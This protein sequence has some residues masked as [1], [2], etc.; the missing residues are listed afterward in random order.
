MRDKYH[1]NSPFTRTQSTKQTNRQN[2]TRDIEMKNSLTVTEGIREGIMEG[3][4]ARDFRNSYK[5]HMD[6][7]NGLSLIHI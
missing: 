1:M 2:I 4:G 7:T 6:I 5:G 3:Q